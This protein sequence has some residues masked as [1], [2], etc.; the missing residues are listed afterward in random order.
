[1]EQTFVTSTV[2]TMALVETVK[3]VNVNERLNSLMPLFALVIGVVMGLTFGLPI[4]ESIIVGLTANGTYSV[5]KPVI[6]PAVDK[7]LS[8]V[9][10]MIK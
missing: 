8:A 7:S 10:G 1:M 6:K 4:V 2:L 9:K 3:R 5:A